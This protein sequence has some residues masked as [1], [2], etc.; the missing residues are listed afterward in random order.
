MWIPLFLRLTMAFVLAVETLGPFVV[1]GVGE[2]IAGTG[3]S[4][5]FTAVRAIGSRTCLLCQ[6][7][8]KGEHA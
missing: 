2:T 6:L 8:W 3:C 4:C 1:F 7:D 5:V